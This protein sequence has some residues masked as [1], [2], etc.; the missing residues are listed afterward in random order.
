MAQ[1]SQAFSLQSMVLVNSKSEVPMPELR[2]NDVHVLLDI[3]QYHSLDDSQAQTDFTKRYND[4]AAQRR[5]TLLS[6][7]KDCDALDRLRFTGNLD[8]HYLRHR[9]ARCLLGRSAVL[10]GLVQPQDFALV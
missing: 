3:I 6:L 4:R 2:K 5:L 8:V 1:F 9:N 7:F 10:N